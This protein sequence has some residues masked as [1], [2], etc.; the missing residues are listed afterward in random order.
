MITGDLEPSS[1]RILVVGHDINQNL[2]KAQQ[3]LGY[4]PQFDSLLPYLTGRETLQLF[5]R[6]RGIQEGLLN[7]EIDQLLNDLKLTKFAQV[8]VSRYSGGSRRKLSLAVALV[9]DVQ[10]VCSDEP[11]TD[12]DPISSL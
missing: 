5:A 10:L 1:G 6:L 7:E 2:L 3:T 12:V 9:G 4:C 8:L 11:T